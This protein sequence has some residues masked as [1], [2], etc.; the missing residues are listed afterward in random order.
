MTEIIE[1]GEWIF[2]SIRMDGNND[3]ING[4]IVTVKHPMFWEKTQIACKNNWT[5]MAKCVGILYNFAFK[6]NRKTIHLISFFLIAV[7]N[8]LVLQE[9]AW[10]F[11]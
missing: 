3:A 11:C 6:T 1:D 4:K 7:W 9:I 2:H 5:T 10:A 8:V